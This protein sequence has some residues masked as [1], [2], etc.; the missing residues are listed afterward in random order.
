MLNNLR[1]LLVDDNVESEVEAEE[2][3]DMQVSNEEFVVERRGKSVVPGQR[4]PLIPKVGVMRVSHF[5]KPL[6][7]VPRC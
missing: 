1:K 3:A 2:D 4:G 6:L 5:F 7:T